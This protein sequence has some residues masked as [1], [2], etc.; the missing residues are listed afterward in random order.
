MLLEYFIAV[1]NDALSK[2]KQSI[3]LSKLHFLPKL[4]GLQLYFLDLRPRLYRNIQAQRFQN[5]GKNVL[6]SKMTNN[7]EIDAWAIFLKSLSY[8][9]QDLSVL[10]QPTIE[11]VIHHLQYSFWSLW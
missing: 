10:F 7:I 2:I 1:L 9:L 8:Y 4:K 3:F 5:W 6:L 11:L